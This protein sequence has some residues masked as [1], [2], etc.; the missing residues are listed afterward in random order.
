MLRLLTE[1]LMRS[2]TW[3]I[4]GVVG[5]V[6][7][8]MDNCKGIHDLVLLLVLSVTDDVPAAAAIIER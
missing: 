5:A 8:W 6:R 2:R 4:M 7:G 3:W 1:L